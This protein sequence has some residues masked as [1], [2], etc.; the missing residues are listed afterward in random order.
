MPGYYYILPRYNDL[1][2]AQQAAVEEPKQIALSG[3]PGTGKS[4][5]SMWR[6][7]SKH[8]QNRNSYLLTYTTTLMRYLQACCH[9]KNINAAKFVGTSYRNKS[10]IYNFH[11]DEVIIDEAQDLESNYFSGICSPVSYGADD[12]QILYPGHSSSQN[13][14]DKMFPDNIVYVL[15]KNFRCTKEIMEF[16]R[17]AFPRAALS[18]KMINNIDRHGDKPSLLI[19][20]WGSMEIVPNDEINAILQIIN[21]LRNDTENIAILLPWKSSV[22]NYV[23]AIKEEVEDFSY[24]FEDMCAFPEGCPELKNVHI[25]TFKSAKGLEFDTV[26]IPDFHKMQ[27]IIGSYNVDWQDYYVGCTRAKS[28]LFLLSNINLPTLSGFVDISRI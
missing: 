8:E 23:S 6:H 3:G 20:S 15:D 7:I 13:Q 18:Y 14:L 16:A 4:V 12:S 17:Q 27:S 26:I 9:S 25:T 21:D 2:T 22:R 10:R 24:Y 11:Y 1:T 28:N 19:G 5:V